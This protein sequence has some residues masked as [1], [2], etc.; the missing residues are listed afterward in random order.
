MSSAVIFFAAFA[1]S[2]LV[3][4]TPYFPLAVGG[5]GKIFNTTGV[6]LASARVWVEV[7][8]PFGWANAT[9]PNATEVGVD[10]ETGYFELEAIVGHVR[11]RDEIKGLRLMVQEPTSGIICWYRELDLA[12]MYLYKPGRRPARP[13]SDRITMR[14]HGEVG[15]GLSYGWDS[16]TCFHRRLAVNVEG[17]IMCNESVP[18]DSA[19][20]VVLVKTK[21][22][23]G[24]HVTVVLEGKT[25]V[26]LTDGSYDLTVSPGPVSDRDEIEGLHLWFANVC[27]NAPNVSNRSNINIPLD[28]MYAYEQGYD[29]KAFVY[30]AQLDL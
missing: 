1:F 11:R 18:M 21:N 25:S 23:T 30:N 22:V 27:E 24:W 17:T 26:T 4:I 5:H 29:Y 9:L 12:Y 13:F 7:D 14:D 19:R 3:P 15:S 16:D 10:K 28:Y 20:M 2:F 8:T 6:P